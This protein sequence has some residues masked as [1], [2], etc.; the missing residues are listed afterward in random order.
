VRYKLA[1]KIRMEDFGIRT[2][3]S[4]NREFICLQRKWKMKTESNERDFHNANKLIVTFCS[5]FG[6]LYQTLISTAHTTRGIEGL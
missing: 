3:D 6:F 4:I 5:S 2:S 1:L